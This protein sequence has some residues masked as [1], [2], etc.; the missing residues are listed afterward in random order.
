MNAAYAQLLAQLMRDRCSSRLTVRMTWFIA[1]CVAAELLCTMYAVKPPFGHAVLLL[2]TGSA[3]YMWCGAFL[4]S[5]AR[6]NQ[7]AYA[8]LVPGLRSRLMT[9]T[10]LLFVAC[11]LAT[12]ALAAVLF[13]HA[14]Y[15]LVCA[16]L[17]TVYMLFAHR[18]PVLNFLPSV[19]IVF[20]LSI[21]ERPLD[22]LLAAANAIGEPVV[23]GVGAIAL[24]LLGML[25]VRT[26][27]PQGGDSHWAWHHHLH[28]Q[29]ARLNG[30]VPATGGSTGGRWTA[31]LRLAYFAALR[32]DS[33]A[34]ASQGR[35]MLHTLGM[36]A[37][38]GNGVA[39]V[40]ASTLAMV[41]VGRYAAG[42]GN[43]D[44]MR[45]ASSAM[46]GC[47][48][49]ASLM[50]AVA[51][52]ANAARY[53]TEQSLYRLTSAAPAAPQ[54]N[55]VLARALLFRCLRLWLISLAGA[56]C[57]DVAMFGELR[58]VTYALAML[59]LPFAGL[60]LRN[61]AAMRRRTGDAAA[62]VVTLLLV[63]A[64]IAALMMERMLP[65]FPWF[66]A[67]SMVALAT[68]AGLRLGWRR[69]LSLPPALPAGRLA[70]ESAAPGWT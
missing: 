35:T 24:V 47:L 49:M 4:K 6:Q 17:F 13:G 22:T 39:Y 69:L 52:S 23:A 19:A 34:G 30:A 28:H 46:Q 48:L 56:A 65:A 61:Y 67:G 33:R 9:L 11:T 45:M 8:C 2:L 70:S 18:Y 58:G 63:L 40:L 57:I 44:V 36:A 53:S 15:A 66:W 42:Q 38:D 26:V 68:A 41:L 1:A 50:Y 31:W 60:T 3:G 21:D 37:H 5:A 14:G 25:G 7:P 12:A 20:S 27:F 55:R 29:T 10:A 16:G 64:Y 62:V 54:L 32:R 59:T 43:P 51:A